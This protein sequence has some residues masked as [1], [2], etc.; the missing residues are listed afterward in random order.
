MGEAAGRPAAPPCRGRRGMLLRSA[1]GR[2]GPAGYPAWTLSVR[3]PEVAEAPAR[4]RPR[5]VGPRPVVGPLPAERV[6]RPEPE[7]VVPVGGQDRRPPARL[8]GDDQ[9]RAPPQD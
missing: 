5:A 2:G 7:G 9:V 3:A 4:P 1:R 8:L 6:R